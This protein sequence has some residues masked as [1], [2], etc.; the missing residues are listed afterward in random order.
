[1]K[2]IAQIDIQ[3]VFMAKDVCVITGKFGEEH[4]FKNSEISWAQSIK[5]GMTYT[6]YENGQQILTVNQ[7]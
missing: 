5:P 3:S 2:V 1:M 6:K 4:R 7:E